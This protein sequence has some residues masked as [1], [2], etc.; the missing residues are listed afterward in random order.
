MCTWH[1]DIHMLYACMHKLVTVNTCT[2]V[3]FTKCN[4]CMVY[5]NSTI[6]YAVS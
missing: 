3:Q 4:V 6:H 2:H 5:E 1:E